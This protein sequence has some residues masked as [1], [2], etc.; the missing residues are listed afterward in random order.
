MKDDRRI[1]VRSQENAGG[2]QIDAEEKKEGRAVIKNTFG[3]LVGVHE[4]W[5]L[6]QF[7]ADV[8]QAIPP[9]S[10]ET[11]EDSSKRTSVSF[12]RCVETRSR[13]RIVHT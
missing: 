9:L 12:L 7:A 4:V 13:T 8:V 10:I 1:A 6:E 5:A 3:G 2:Q 11:E